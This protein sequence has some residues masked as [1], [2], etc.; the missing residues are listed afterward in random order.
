ML[1]YSAD[2]NGARGGEKEQPQMRRIQ[3]RKSAGLGH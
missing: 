2:K 1:N 3:L